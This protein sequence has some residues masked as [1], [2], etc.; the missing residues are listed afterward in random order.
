[1]YS[2]KGSGSA[3]SGMSDWY[4]Q[5]LS[6][7]VLA[8]LLPLPFFLLIAVYHGSIDQQ[9]L[10]YIVNHL[11]TRLL[12]TVLIAAL[13]IHI[14]AGLKVIIE[15]YVHVAGLRTVLIGTM[16][17]VMFVFAISWLAVIWAWGG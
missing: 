13:I 3:H 9:G 6:A 15:D 11:L 4:W 2:V 8:V 14:N 16:F 12:S 17:V 5:R 7:V 1:M 10:Q